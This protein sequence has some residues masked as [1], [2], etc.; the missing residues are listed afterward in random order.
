MGGMKKIRLE[1]SIGIKKTFAAILVVLWKIACTRVKIK[2]LMTMIKKLLWMS[3]GTSCHAH[4]SA[5]MQVALS[6]QN[7]SNHRHGITT[8]V[9]SGWIRANYGMTGARY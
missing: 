8:S 4:T 6:V 7:G 2:M 3:A 1:I 9:P 5:F